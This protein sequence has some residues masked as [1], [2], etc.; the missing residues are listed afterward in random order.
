MLSLARACGIF[1]GGAMLAAGAGA[2]A[3]PVP[4]PVPTHWVPYAA[5][6]SGELQHRLSD[7][8]GDLVTRLHAWLEQPQV[9]AAHAEPWVVRIWISAQGR[10]ERAEFRTLGSPQADADLRALLAAKPLSALPP[11]D[12]QQPL[13]LGLSL[14][15][16]PD[17][18]PSG[19]QR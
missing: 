6:A 7:E 16:N 9:V 17:Y 14:R 8:G 13:V 12:M 2:T 1:V 3:T 11:A 19:S 5:L 4:A 18:A 15:A 10:I